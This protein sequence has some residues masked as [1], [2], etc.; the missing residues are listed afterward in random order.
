MLSAAVIILIVLVV[1]AALRILHSA[2]QDVRND[3]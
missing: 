2:A 1:I 3:Y